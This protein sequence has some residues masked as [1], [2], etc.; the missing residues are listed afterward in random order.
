MSGRSPRR[1]G[2]L[3]LACSV[4]L[5]GCTAHLGKPQGPAPTPVITDYEVRRDLRFTP[6]D[7][8]QPLLG[9]A[10]VPRGPGPF[11]GVL[12]IHG[13]GW[14]SGDRAQV[15]GIAD[16]L[17]RR[18]FV[19]F[20]TTYRLAPAYT[21]PAPLQDVQLALR[22][23][24]THADELRIRPA[25]IG[26][27]GY[28]AGAHL[29]ALLGTVSPGDPL[30]Q[31]PRA[32]AVVAGGTPADL[33]QFKGGRLVPQ[34]LG[35]N[36]QTDPGA[37]RRAS[38]QAYVTADDAPFFLYHGSWDA[39]VPASQAQSMHDTLVAAGVRSELFWLR[40]RGHITAFLTDGAAFDAAAA[41]LDRE[42]R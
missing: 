39:L 41:F 17:A 25:R 24:Q 4:V 1:R 35:T 27:F 34:F 26:A 16:R 42:L 21:F 32:A 15:A 38:P 30:F 36:W 12:L 3:A 11:P 14:E 33:T 20:N 28:S 8:P 40:G 7:W 5:T 31:A 2:L 10:Y 19:V 29:A 9:D 22:W 18:G 37:Y 23:M 13:G 6:E